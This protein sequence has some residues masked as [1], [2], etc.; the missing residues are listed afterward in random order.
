MIHPNAP[1]GQPTKYAQRERERRFLMEAVPDR[2]CVRRAEILDHYLANTRLRLRR[3]MVTSGDVTVPYYKLTQKVPSDD[4]SPGLISTLYLS[5]A[6]Y[7]AFCALPA[8]ALTKVRYSIPPLGVD[9]FDAAL[10]GLILAEAEFGDDKEM[11]SFCPPD[12]CVAEVTKDRRFNGG[13]LA[14]TER[15]A[16]VTLLDEFGIAGAGCRPSQTERHRGRWS[17]IDHSGRSLD[18]ARPVGS[19][20]HIA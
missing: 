17:R 3:M 19:S 2:R 8:R 15:G 12:G 9:V 11:A 6:E 4:G 18:Q 16:L 14:G 20:A 5:Q 1:P 7:V 13:V 10:T